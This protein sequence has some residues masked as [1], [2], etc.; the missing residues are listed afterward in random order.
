M[1]RKQRA[2]L[3]PPPDCSHQLFRAFSRKKRNN[4]ANLHIRASIYKEQRGTAKEDLNLKLPFPFF[5]FFFFKYC[6]F[7][8]ETSNPNKSV[9]CESRRGSVTCPQQSHLHTPAALLILCSRGSSRG[10][11]L[12]YLMHK[13]CSSCIGDRRHTV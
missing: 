11:E 2:A 4:I 9:S 10:A 1:A 12:L 8:E 3:I 5:S 13:C 6:S 7:S